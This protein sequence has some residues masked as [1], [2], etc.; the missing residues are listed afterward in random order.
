MLGRGLTV[1]ARRLDGRSQ[2]ERLS[3]EHLAERA[4]GNPK[5]QQVCDTAQFGGPVRKW[6]PPGPRIKGRPQRTP[7]NVRPEHWIGAQEFS[8]SYIAIPL[9]MHGVP[10]VPRLSAATCAEPNVIGDPTFCNEP[11]ESAWGACSC[12][13]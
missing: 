6:L 2:R 13:G 9:I 3:V 4:P 11:R 5:G 7:V 12:P 10:V 8:L 1:V